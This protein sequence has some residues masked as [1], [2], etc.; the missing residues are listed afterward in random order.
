MKDNTY[1]EMLITTFNRIRKELP[2][3]YAIFHLPWVLE[4][5]TGTGQ[6]KQAYELISEFSSYQLVAINIIPNFIIPLIASPIMDRLPRKPFLVGGDFIIGILY[7][8][9]GIYLLNFQFTYIGY[10]LFTLLLTFLSTFD[11]LAYQ[12]IYPDLITED[13]EEKGYTVSG[14]IYPVMQVVVAPV[15]AVLMKTIG[16]ANILIIQGGCSI[17]AAITESN[18]KIEEKNRITD[19]KISIFYGGKT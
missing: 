12:S 1:G 7:A 16:V 14:M 17:L 19:E 2:S 5:Y 6:Y 3:G 13:F 11:Y 10:L 8:L 15:A 18:I 4:W 9:A